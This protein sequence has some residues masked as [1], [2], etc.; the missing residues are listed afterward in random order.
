RLI[1]IF[2]PHRYSR[3]KELFSE[4]LGCFKE[5]DRLVLSE[6][7]PAGETP[8]P[9]ISGEALAAAMQ[10]PAVAFYPVLHDCVAE[11][12]RLAEPGDVILTVGAGSIGQLGYKLI[13]QLERYERAANA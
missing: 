6:I 2:Q 11:V 9:G 12:A 10:H 7:Y 3:T 4:F 8:I 5:A 13:E 1:V